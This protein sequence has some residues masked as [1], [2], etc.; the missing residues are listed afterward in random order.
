MFCMLSLSSPLCCLHTTSSNVPVGWERAERAGVWAMHTR[1]WATTSRPCTSLRDTWTSP[2]RY[3]SLDGFFVLV[4]VCV[5][6]RTH[7]CE[8]GGSPCW[9]AYCIVVRHYYSHSLLVTIHFLQCKCT[10]TISHY[11][12]PSVQVPLFPSLIT[13]HRVAGVESNT[14]TGLVCPP[15]KLCWASSPSPCAR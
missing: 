8:W 12:L 2:K 5:W 15:S 3:V 1:P 14:W 9:C 13:S 10:F 4:C 7:T 6:A 11:S